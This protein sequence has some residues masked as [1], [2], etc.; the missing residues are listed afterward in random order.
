[1]NSIILWIENGYCRQGKLHFFQKALV[2]VALSQKPE[3]RVSQGFVGKIK[4]STLVGQLWI[5]CLPGARC[6]PRCWGFSCD[7]NIL[8]SLFSWLSK[9]SESE[10]VWRPAEKGIQEQP[11]ALIFH[12]LGL[13]KSLLPRNFNLSSLNLCLP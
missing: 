2:S 12:R 1:M 7:H 10:T 8:P 13:W 11:R 9:T 4:T 3:K 6:S 5:Q